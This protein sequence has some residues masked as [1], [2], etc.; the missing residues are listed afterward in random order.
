MSEENQSNSKTDSAANGDCRPVP[1]SPFC[2]ICGGSGVTN[3]GTLGEIDAGDCDACEK[4]IVRARLDFEDRATVNRLEE[5]VC[6][7]DS[8]E[9]V[10]FWAIG[11]IRFL[12]ANI[13]IEDA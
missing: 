6:E 9:E 10:L 5:H 3:C 7:N 2:D 1:C 8:L 11:R 13:K 12:E 4:G